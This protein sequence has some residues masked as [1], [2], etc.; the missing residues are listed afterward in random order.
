MD[1]FGTGIPDANMRQHQESTVDIHMK[2]K[3][4][5]HLSAP[6][7]RLILDFQYILFLFTAQ[8][9]EEAH[10]TNPRGFPRKKK[11]KQSY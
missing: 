1:V 6:P 8:E 11:G 3:P 7:L 9:K 10:W 4:F 5:V 2:D